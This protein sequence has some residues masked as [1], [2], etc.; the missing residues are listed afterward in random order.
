MIFSLLIA[1]IPLLLVGGFSY[2]KSTSVIEEKVGL[3]NFKT[4][5]QIAENLNFILNDMSQSSIYLAQ[6]RA[7]IHYL[8]LP[9]QE[10]R[11]SRNDLLATQNAVNSFV[12]FK[13]DIHSIYVQGMNGLVFDTASNTNKLD[14]ELQSRLFGLR[15]EGM[16]IADEIIQY[17]GSELPV[18]SFIKVLKDIDD[19]SSNLAIIKIN[20]AE[21]QFSAVYRDKLLGGSVDFFIIDEKNTVISSLDK[22]KLGLTLE[23]KLN[24]PRLHQD[25]NGYFKTTLD[26]RQFIQT[27]Y[28]LSRPGWKLV[29]LMPMNELS[30]DTKIIRNITLYAVSGSFALCLLMI[31]LFS[32]RV[33]SPLNRISKAMKALE[34]EN[35]NINIHVR[36]N[37]EIA[38]I[39]TSFNRMSK[40]LNELINEVYAVQIKRKE[41]ELEALQAQIN[42][43]FLYNTLDTIYWMCRME[44][45]HE[46]SHLV[47]ALSKLF[48]LSLNS[49][50]EFTTVGKEI[51]H[52][53]YYMAIQ[54]KRFEDLIHFQL[55]AAEDTLNCKAV[56][57]VLQPLVENAIHHGIERKG[58]RGSIE[59]DIYKEENRLIYRITD[60][61]AGADEAEL[62]ALLG[63]VEENNRGLGIK[64]VNDRIRL[65]FGPSYGISFRSAPGQGMA[66]IVSQPY[67]EEER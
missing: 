31:V 60:D 40:R 52:L 8:K 18:I 28:N 37:D 66:V 53:K 16:W 36:G 41:A 57:I 48:R 30:R 13:P 26:G 34:K 4:V 17:D 56:K 58:C 35:F 20:V 12:V 54:E 10:V 42:P 64:N 23:D 2:V 39:G 43:H 21:E 11:Q 55:R 25:E 67:I 19:L 32:F 59:V 33:L 44:K 5:Q 29:N 45:A 62:N 50:N 38:L 47:Q 51:E 61:G 65:Y 49:G 7:F 14:G 27:Y 3:S 46:S 24:D 9:S 63:K 1:I 6:N 15:G 22:A